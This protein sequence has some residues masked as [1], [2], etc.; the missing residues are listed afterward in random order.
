MSKNQI[1]PRIRA[2]YGVGKLTVAD[3][4]SQRKNG[5]MVW[6][7]RCDCGGEIHLDTRA[8]QRG[9]VRDCGCE[10][11]VKPGQRDITG[12]VFGKLTAV[13]PSGQR[14]KDGSVVWHCHCECGGQVDVSLHQLHFGYRKSCGCLSRP[15]L[16]DL[17]GKR[18]GM[19]TVSAYEG[20]VDGIHCW[21]CRCDCGNETVVRSNSLISGHTKSCG[22]LQKE[23]VLDNL[24]LVDGTS[25]T[26]LEATKNRLIA[27]NTSGHRGVYQNKRTQ[28][29]AAQITFKGKTHYLGS[30]ENIEDA[31]EARRRGEEEM[32]DDFLK[33]Y[34]EEYLKKLD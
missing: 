33:W 32:H 3:V 11:G 24:R 29:W 4:T 9:T 10:A 6:L 18:F 23:Q 5:Y 7:C 12:E 31:V 28:K 25:V 27:S 26:M 15:P 13:Y 34:Y 30:F 22:C 17:V 21:R 2:G 8:L 14:G 20:K 1:R 16:E 19:L